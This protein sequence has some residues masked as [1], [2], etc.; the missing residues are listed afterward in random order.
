MRSLIF[1]A[2]ATLTSATQSFTGVS[3]GRALMEVTFHRVGAA[4]GAAVAA[5][6][7]PRSARA[8]STALVYA[9]GFKRRFFENIFQQ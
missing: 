3:A 4:T 9:I 6:T 8:S 1:K 5:A 7:R 2:L